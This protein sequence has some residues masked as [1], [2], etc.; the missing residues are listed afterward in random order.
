[1]RSVEMCVV[2]RTST[3]G[4]RHN[5]QMSTT[6]LDPLYVSYSPFG[7]LGSIQTSLDVHLSYHAGP[8]VSNACVH[9]G[10]W[11]AFMEYNDAWIRAANAS[12]L[13]FGCPQSGSTK[14][15]SSLSSWPG[16][17][18]LGVAH[19]SCNGVIFCVYIQFVSTNMAYPIPAWLINQTLGTETKAIHNPFEAP[20]GNL[21]S[22]TRVS[23]CPCG[24]FHFILIETQS[25]PRYSPIHFIFHSYAYLF[26]A[27]ATPTLNSPSCLPPFPLLHLSISLTIHP[28]PT[29][30]VTT[31]EYK[32][33]PKL[34]PTVYPP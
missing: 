15:R 33:P 20:C 2:A 3:F 16:Q 26:I 18:D 28:P 12:A 22:K 6:L 9:A 14:A 23:H 25:T 21:I 13:S 19:G 8:R 30:T 31:R 7:A 1:M 10:R 32:R 5:G 17:V 4:V 27:H 34:A 29:L 24:T 11:T